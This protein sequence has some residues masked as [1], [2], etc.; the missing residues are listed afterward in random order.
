VSG[1]SPIQISEHIQGA[2]FW[3]AFC[4]IKNVKKFERHINRAGVIA[5]SQN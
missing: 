5:M 2:A 3:Y 1:D 4:S